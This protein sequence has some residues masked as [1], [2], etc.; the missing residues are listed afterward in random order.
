VFAEA[1]VHFIPPDPASKQNIEEAFVGMRIEGTKGRTLNIFSLPA[2]DY[3]YLVCKYQ[4]RRTVLRAVFRIHDIIDLQDANKKRIFFRSFSAYR[5]LV[6]FEGT[7]TSFFKDKKS[8]RSHK[9]EEIKVFLTIF[10]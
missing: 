4:Y 7:F 9:T 2:A 1:G 10:A 5:T 3:Q 8:K 6:L